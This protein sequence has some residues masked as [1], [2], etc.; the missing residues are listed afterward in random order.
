MDLHQETQRLIVGGPSLLLYVIEWKE[1]EDSSLK[2]FHSITLLSSVE[3]MIDL[4]WIRQGR[5][6]IVVQS[7]GSVAIYHVKKRSLLFTL[8]ISQRRPCTTITILS[9]QTSHPLECLSTHRDGTFSLWS[10]F[11]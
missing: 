9:D 8:S 11:N 7:D 10:L 5:A 2:C 3:G 1:E 4:H 6:C